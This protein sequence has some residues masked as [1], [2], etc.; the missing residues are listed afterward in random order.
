MGIRVSSLKETEGYGFVGGGVCAARGFTANGLRCGLNDT[1]GKNDLGLIACSRDCSTAGVYTTNKVK[2]APITVTKSH[3]AAS[4]G[5]SRAVI[6]NSRNA[7]TCNE[8][9]VMKAEK[10][11]SLAAE[12]L[13]ISPQ[14]VLVASTGVI[15]QVLPIEPIESKIGELAAGLCREGHLEAEKAVMTTDTVPKE[16]AVEFMCGGKKCSLGGMAKGSGMIDPHMATTL[17]FI[18]TDADISSVLLQT[19]LSDVV[20]TTYNCL[21]VDG[22]MSTNDMVLLMADGMAGNERIES[23]DSEDYAVFRGALYCVMMNLTRMLAADGEGATKLIECDVTGA[24]DPEQAVTAAKS[25]VSS[26]L[27]KCAVFGGDANW[28]RIL[29]A[30]GYADA[31]YDIGKVSVSISSSAGS[32]DVCRN[33]AGIPFSEEKAAAV[34]AENEIT[35]SV[36]LHQGHESAAAWGCDLTYDYVKINGDYRS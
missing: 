32:V 18:T 33:G 4:G 19:A 15:G 30:L 36:D 25:V 28:G 27:F 9:G 21:S 17:N 7:N 5:V 11:C 26:N 34:L 20:R 1:P 29:C 13:G 16:A 10:M 23:Q 3:I 2:G 31:S 24:P 8:D 12:A 14:K 6:M 35:V 22:D